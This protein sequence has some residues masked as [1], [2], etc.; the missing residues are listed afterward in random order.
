LALIVEDEQDTADAYREALRFTGVRAL[1]VP[2]GRE[3]LRRD[4]ELLPDLIILHHRRTFTAASC[5]VSCARIPT[6]C[7]YRSSW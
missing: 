6:R 5:A 1:T 7:R 2:N 4:E 3:A